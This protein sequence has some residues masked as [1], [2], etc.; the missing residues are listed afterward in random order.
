MYLPGITSAEFLIDLKAIQ[1]YK[2]IQVIVLSTIKSD[3]EIE[4]YKQMGAVEYVQKSALIS[5]K[6]KFIDKAN[7]G[8][9]W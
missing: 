7:H 1:P 6:L 3:V 4:R 5:T 2:D 9:I 8:L